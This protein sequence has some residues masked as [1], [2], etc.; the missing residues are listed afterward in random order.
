M[1]NNTLLGLVRIG[2]VERLTFNALY[3][4][5]NKIENNIKNNWFL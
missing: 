3:P 2:R 5:D 4:I 1:L